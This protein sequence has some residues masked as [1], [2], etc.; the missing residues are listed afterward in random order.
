MNSSGIKRG[1]AV[2]AISALAIAGIPQIANADTITEQQATATSVNLYTQYSGQASVQNDGVN[3]TVHLLAGGGA[4]IT[5]V[6]FEYGPAA[7]PTT[8]AT[9]S[10]TNGVFSTEWAPPVAIYGTTVAIRAVGLN[11]VGNVVAGATD[12]NAATIGANASAVDIANAPAS[13]VGVFRQPYGV[14]EPEIAGTPFNGVSHDTAPAIIT[15]TTSGAGAVQLSDLSDGSRVFPA[16]AANPVPSAP[17][18]NGIRTFKGT[19]N[20]SDYTFDATAPIVNEAIVGANQTGGSD[21]AEVLNL[22]SRP[23]PRSPPPPTRPR[24]RTAR[25]PLASSP[26]STSSVCRCRAPRSSSTLTRTVSGT[27]TSPRATP[28]PTAR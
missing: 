28:T 2:S 22:A 23:S 18:A 19:A 17:D 10:R 11:S 6:R 1:L 7:T 27:P 5:Q 25:P 20:F 4:T 8:I 3:Q 24:S 26:C 15:G 21:D 13:T 14:E 16:A 12:E 9:V